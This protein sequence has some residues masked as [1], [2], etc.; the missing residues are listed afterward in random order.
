MI[1]VYFTLLAVIVWS[2]ANIIDKYI[3]H[4]Y[5]KKP[6]VAT[7]FLATISFVSAIITL[8]FIQVTIPT[9]TIFGFAILAGLCYTASNYFY[10]KSLLSEEVSRIITLY[11]LTPI[12]VLLFSTPFL[13]ELFSLTQY[14]GIVL[15]IMGSVLIS[16]RRDVKFRVSKALFYMVLGTVF[17]A[18]NY[19][20]T[21][22]VLNTISIWDAFF[23]IRIG[24][25]L[26][27]PFLVGVFHKQ[28]REIIRSS[29]RGIIY[30]AFNEGLNIVGVLLITLAISFGFVSLTS[31]LGQTQPIFVLLFAAILSIYMPWIIRE[32]LKGSAIL[33]KLIAIIIT[34]AGTILI[35]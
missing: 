26:A 29:P 13:G 2:I 16:L 25:A 21:K 33:M 32:E 14:F 3:M 8:L 19:V 27:V 10:Y 4:F 24:S 31:T 12:F 17:L 30:Q 7:T 28:I 11:A 15:V 35:I 22:H 20:I 34:I 1:W 23:W 9:A 18:I 6:A 5:I